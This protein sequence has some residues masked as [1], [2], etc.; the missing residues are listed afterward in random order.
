MLHSNFARQ[1]HRLPSR[2]QV[3]VPVTVL[4]FTLQAPHNLCMLELADLST[5]TQIPTTAYVSCWKQSH[6]QSCLGVSLDSRLFILK[7]EQIL[8]LG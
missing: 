8:I 5:L 7:V 3:G 4:A 2:H 6:P 1:L